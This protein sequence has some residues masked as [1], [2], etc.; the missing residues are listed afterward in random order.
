MRC[1]G[2]RLDLGLDWNVDARN[3]TIGKALHFDFGLGVDLG[4]AAVRAESEHATL[5]SEGSS[6]SDGVT[7]DAFAISA[8]LNAR[9][10]APYVA[11]VFPVDQD[12]K[13]IFSFPSPPVPSSGCSRGA[14]RTARGEHVQG[15]PGPAVR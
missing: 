1:A 4:P 10:I 15:I 3:S 7:I 13:G 11:W 5:F 12:L 9:S 8:R 6:S 2:A 14:P